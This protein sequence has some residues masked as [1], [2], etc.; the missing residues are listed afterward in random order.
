MIHI[1]ESRRA[2]YVRN[3]RTMSAVSLAA[4]LLYLKW[5]L[6]DARPSNMV[7]FVMLMTAEIFNIAQ[8]M[9]FWYTISTQ[10]WIEPT[11]PPF[12]QTT[13]T[14]DIYVT[15]CGEPIEIVSATVAAA[16]RIR[17]PRKAV[18]VLDDGKSPEVE[19][20]AKRLFAGYLTRPDNRGAKAGNLNDAMKRTNGTFVVIFDADHVPVPE[21]LEKT[22]GAFSDDRVSFVQTPQV[23][24]N[25]TVNRVS[26][27]AHDQQGLFYGPIMRGKNATGAVFSCGTNVIFR[28]SA[29][30][31]IGG[32]PE[33][34]ITEDLRVSLLLLKAG[35]RSIYVPIELARG[36]GPV[37]VGSFFSQQF[38][39]A[40]G[41]LEILF[42]RSPYF[43]GMARGAKI[44]YSLGFLYW[45]TGFAYAIYLILPPAYLFFGL[46][47][48]QVPNE[49]PVYFVPYIIST[50]L[51]L[52]YAA[53][54]KLSFA[55]VWFTLGSFPVFIKAFFSAIGGRAARFVV[56]SKGRSELSLRPVR[57]HVATLIVLVSSVVW[58]L[59]AYGV[60]P[61]VMNNVAF[62]LGHV[63]IVQGF[64]RYALRTETAW[65]DEIDVFSDGTGK[66]SASAVMATAVDGERS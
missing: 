48:V 10:R 41:G 20:M 63:L 59:L 58:G 60:T 11:I 35:Y 57:V 56:T 39:W 43:R 27:G 38:R 54:F 45:F 51:T 55:G 44:Q 7:L 17:H 50:L 49:Y 40:R 66:D 34:S 53:D 18:W 23:Y 64:V 31:R 3:C 28:R 47:P 8:A 36:M 62:A 24:A 16:M 22:L 61:S 33:D 30:E 6:F 2:S 46:R 15:V 37:D 14:V 29:L 9:G 4:A 19:Q 52:A 13:E 25:R 32:M 12:D 42:H 21:F 1:E 26:A 65:V 5:L